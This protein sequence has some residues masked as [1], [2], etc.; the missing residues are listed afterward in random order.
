MT[1]SHACS[2]G[3]SH[4]HQG[5]ESL[6]DARSR[7]AM[8]TRLSLAL[9][10][11]GML[12]LSLVVRSAFPDQTDVADLAA[13][14]AALLVGIPVFIDAWR[15]LWA[16]SLHGVTDELVAAALLAAWAAGDLTSA[17]LVPLLMVIGH[18]LEDRSLLGSR[19]AITALARLTR[20]KARR[21]DERGVAADVSSEE[22]RPGDRIELRAG[23]RAPADGVVRSG[24]SIVD[25]APITGESVP[26]D[27]APGDAIA[28]GAINLGACVEIEVMRVGEETTLGRVVKLMHDAEQA[29]PPITRLLEKHA[30]SYLALVVLVAA[31]TWL[32]TGSLRTALAVLVASCPCALVIAAPA[33]SV[34]ALA[35]AA[36]HGILVR[37][38]AFLEELSEVDSVI[39]DKTGTVTLGELRLLRIV[40]V[41][42]AAPGHLLELAGSLGAASSHPVSRA[43]AEAVAPTHR[44]RMHE[45]RE[46]AGMGIVAR[47]DRS[48]DGVATRVALGRTEFLRELGIAVPDAPAHDGPV[49]GLATDEDFLGWL[50]LAD[51]PRGEARHALDDLRSLGLSRQILLTGD[52]RSVAQTIAARLGIDD[53]VAEVLPEQKLARV[54]EEVRAGRR[55]LVVGDGVN[56][57]L[58]LKA[59]AVGVA[60]GARGTDVALA[61]SD[62]VLMTS[63]LRRLGTCVR[64]ARRARRAIAI[65]VAIGLGWTLVVLALAAIG[66]VAAPVAA[67][68]H[69][70]GTLAVLANAGRLLHFDE[71]D[72]T[73]RKE[74]DSD[75]RP[76]DAASAIARAP[77]GA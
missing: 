52:R 1:T 62:V 24:T 5:D 28:A 33:T 29:K 44:L 6:L 23:D 74:V 56:D 40:P 65:N 15:S 57:A 72:A 11:A 20:T 64:L 46:S 12:V 26:I 67:V 50:F 43:L 4:A 54:L 21:L 14:A 55:P 71:T 48:G 75:A 66:K 60:M 7:R 39:L 68:L 73:V 51:E 19:E 16:P 8:A 2:A 45:V 61:S 70:V 18:V 3:A 69:N 17:A 36:R 53:V 34:A 27:V 58:A 49:V 10:A 37:G 32:L 9:V 59:G 30:N 41:G 13:M 42:S 77:A 25:T 38:T 22:L 31:A 63:D 47:L 35:V 76:A